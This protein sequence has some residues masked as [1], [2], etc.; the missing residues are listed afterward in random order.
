MTTTAM[1]ATIEIVF[2]VIILNVR[3]GERSNTKN[4]SCT[5]DDNEEDANNDDDNG[6]KRRKMTTSATTIV[7]TRKM[8][9]GTR[10]EEEEMFNRIN[11]QKD[12][13]ILH[14]S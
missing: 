5:V 11:K 10:G 2:I 12:N 6:S 8:K 4:L 3:Q 9:T 7:M 1:I 14:T 13:D